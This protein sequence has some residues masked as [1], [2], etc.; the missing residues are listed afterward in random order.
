MKKTIIGVILAAGN[1]T[2][3]KTKEHKTVKDFNDKPMI[4]YGF[5]LFEKIM[6]I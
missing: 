2:R 5:D 6:V 3:F 4:V 1:S